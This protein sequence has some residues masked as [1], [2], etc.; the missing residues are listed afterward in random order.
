MSDTLQLRIVTLAEPEAPPAPRRGGRDRYLDLL[1]A[2]ALVRVVLFHMFGWAWLPIVFP[3]MGV[4]FALAGSLMA[5]SLSRPAFSVI[6]GRL[7]RLLPPMWLLGAIVIPGMVLQGWRPGAGN[8]AVD[9]WV[10]LFYWI[11]PISDPPYAEQLHHVPGLLDAYWGEH[12]AGPLWYLRAYL[13]FVLLSPLLLRAVRRMPWLTMTAPILLCVAL[14]NELIPAPDRIWSVISGISTY[15]A[16]WILGMAF[17]EGLL[18]RVP[19]YVLPSIM[20]FFMGAA[21]WWGATHTDR[22]ESLNMNSTTLS[23]A[24]WSFGFVVLLLHASPSWEEW[25]PRLQRW[26]GLITL[27]NS[28]AVSVYLWHNL[29]VTT[30]IELT[31]L[32]WYND[33]LVK[34]ASWLLNSNWPAFALVIPLI[35]L[36]IA[37]FGWVEDLAA[38]R[39]PRLFPYPRR[40]RGRRRAA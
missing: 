38:K 6:R 39:S 25:P 22:G 15:G 40:Q 18:K 36:C 29:A 12:A 27:L 11:L 5:R 35:A 7:R 21:L 13:W 19:G 16:C 26:N 24:V 30:A 23:E 20:P 9:W 33:F 32:L 34:H 37:V 3:S 28:R 14:D 10:N 31:G 17:N 4:M 2:L 1:R 8:N